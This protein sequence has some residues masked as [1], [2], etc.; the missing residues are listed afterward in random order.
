MN[1]CR[2]GPESDVYVYESDEGMEC[3]GCYF[4][5]GWTHP[6]PE[7]MTAHLRKH[8]AAGHKVPP[9]VFDLLSDYQM[10]DDVEATDDC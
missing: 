6:N 1:L 8:V 3:C 2:F 10:L 5:N 4:G 7:A 9:H